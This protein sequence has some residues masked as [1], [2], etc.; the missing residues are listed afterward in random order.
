MKRGKLRLAPPIRPP[1]SCRRSPRPEP[2]ASRRSSGPTRRRSPLTSPSLPVF[3]NP[4]FGFPP[5]ASE[6]SRRSRAPRS[7]PQDLDTDR[8]RR[9]PLSARWEPGQLERALLVRLQIRGPATASPRDAKTPTPLAMRDIAGDLRARPVR[10]PRLHRRGR[11]G[12]AR[13]LARTAAGTCSRLRPLLRFSKPARSNRAVPIDPTVHSRQRRPANCRR[14][15]WGAGPSAA[16]A[17]S[18]PEPPS[19]SP[20]TPGATIELVPT[21]F[22]QV[23]RG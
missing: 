11:P 12:Y 3:S 14:Y 21:S 15:P 5:H 20:V 23:E 1:P 4:P 2:L 10:Q 13:I 6:S 17:R 8:P 16:T 9:G 22:P 19:Q 18:G 7:R